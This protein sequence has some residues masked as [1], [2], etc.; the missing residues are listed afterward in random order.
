MSLILKNNLGVTSSLGIP[1]TSK[2]KKLS[3][4]DSYFTSKIL[5]RLETYFSKYCNRLIVFNSNP[6]N[7]CIDSV[8][9]ICKP[10]VSVH[11]TYD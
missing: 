6:S 3:L 1:I 7:V 11:M 5:I 4:F 9:A 8:V 2:P 10:T